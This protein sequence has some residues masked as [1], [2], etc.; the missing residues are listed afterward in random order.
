MHW[1]HHKV[2]KYA[3]FDAFF[4]VGCGLMLIFGSLLRNSCL[5]ISWMIVTVFV[6]LKYIWVVLTYDWTDME[7]SNTNKYVS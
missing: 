2:I 4:G 6:S 3:A 7:V 5:L 1:S